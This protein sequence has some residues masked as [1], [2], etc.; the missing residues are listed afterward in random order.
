MQAEATKEDPSMTEE[1]VDMVTGAVTMT[2]E[3]LE[4]GDRARLRLQGKI[5]RNN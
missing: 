4:I 1:V 3:P 2:I 5:T